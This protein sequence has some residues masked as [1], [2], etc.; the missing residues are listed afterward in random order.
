MGA[1][2]HDD[3]VG[4]FL[5]EVVSADDFNQLVAGQVRQVVEGFHA[6]FAEGDQVFRAQRLDG[7]DFIADTQSEA[8]FLQLAGFLIQRGLGAALQFG[9]DIFIKALDGGEFIQR[10]D[11]EVFD[12]LKA[13][14]HQQ[15]GDDVVHVQ[16][17]DEEAGF[18]A[19]F[20]L[21]AFGF[22]GF[23]Q[24]VDVPA[25]ELG[26]EADVLAAAADGL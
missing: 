21:A 17:V 20:F 6:F 4:G 10:G 18:A 9:G 14:G 26:G 11:G 13:F 19:E 3:L 23:G 8:A 7:G 15:A 25:G 16:R 2:G 22:F 24:D 12:G 1:G 5:G